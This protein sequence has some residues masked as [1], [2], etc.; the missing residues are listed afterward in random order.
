MSPK[1]TALPHISI[2]LSANLHDY[3]A[4]WSD[5][6]L[7]DFIYM[8]LEYLLTEHL[9]DLLQPHLDNI[10]I[11]DVADAT[12]DNTSWSSVDIYNRHGDEDVDW[13]EIQ[14][15]V[16]EFCND[17]LVEILFEYTGDYVL[18]D[19]YDIQLRNGEAFTDI[20]MPNHLIP[21]IAT[22]RLGQSV[23]GEPEPLRLEDAWDLVPVLEAL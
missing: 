5:P 21:E 20:W 22:I 3:V 4:G 8:E 12:I 2:D 18:V 1:T 13:D 7:N 15:Y 23:A 9:Q 10:C 16:N 14:R 11:I 17:Y 19:G 6:V